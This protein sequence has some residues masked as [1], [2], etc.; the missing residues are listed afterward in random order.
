V[1]LRRCGAFWLDWR[2]RRSGIALGPVKIASIYEAGMDGF[3][4]HRFLEANDVESHVV[5]AASTAVDRRSR[6]AK[7]DRTDVEKLL[8]TLM[9]W[10]RRER[11]LKTELLRELDRLELVMSQLAK[12][13]A[14]RDKALRANQVMSEQVGK[15]AAAE[16]TSSVKRVRSCC[17]YGVSG[18]SLPR[19]F[20]WRRFCH[21]AIWTG[22]RSWDVG[23]QASLAMT[24]YIDAVYY[25]IRSREAAATAVADRASHLVNR[26]C[27]R[28]DQLCRSP[29]S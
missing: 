13:E 5:D 8:H 15:E 17:A 19:Y 24:W 27:L 10:A 25:P 2:R 22:T 6:R 14:G 28:S 20:H 12:L 16:T 29:H 26:H 9:G 7:T 3:W 23:D 11:R 18:Q 1:M 4:V 21:C